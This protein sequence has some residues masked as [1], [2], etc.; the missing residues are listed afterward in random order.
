MARTGGGPY[1]GG[2]SALF[3]EDRG[4]GWHW[5]QLDGDAPAG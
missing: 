5:I 4:G 2:A 1:S 3:E